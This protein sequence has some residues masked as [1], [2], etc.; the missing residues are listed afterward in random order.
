[1]EFQMKASRKGI[2]RNRFQ[3]STASNPMPAPSTQKQANAQLAFLNA[4]LLE[5]ET[6][7]AEAYYRRACKE[8]INVR[9]S[10]PAG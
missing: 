7:V 9:A 1:M 2:K 6:P 10:L 5:A 4:K 3:T 8:I